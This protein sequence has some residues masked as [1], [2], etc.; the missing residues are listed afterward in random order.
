MVKLDI[1]ATSCYDPIL[2]VLASI[3]SRSFGVH[4]NVTLVTAKTLKATR[5]KLKTMLGVLAEWY[6]HSE[7][8]PIYGTGQGSGNLYLLYLVLRELSPLRHL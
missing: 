6:S 1:D 4:R 5:Y 3:I 7:E 2:P 8:F